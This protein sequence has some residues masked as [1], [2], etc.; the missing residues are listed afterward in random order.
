MPDQNPPGDGPNKAPTGTPGAPT[1]PTGE[2]TPEE[3]EQ[4]RQPS[5]WYNKKDREASFRMEDARWATSEQIKDWLK[6]AVMVAITLIWC[7]I[8]YLSEP[9]LR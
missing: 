7:A 9:G 8:V 2:P 5:F 3:K 1:R 6:L 4:F